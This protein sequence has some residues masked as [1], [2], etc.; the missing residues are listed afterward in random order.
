MLACI[1]REPLLCKGGYST[2]NDSSL[3]VFARNPA[4]LSDSDYTLYFLQEFM[5]VQ[6]PSQNNWAIKTRK[7]SYVIERRSDGR[8][9]IAFHW[10]PSE[11][12]KVQYAHVHAEMVG[13][14]RK[15]HIPT[16]RVP[17]EDVVSFAIH[18][19]GV[20]PLQSKWKR[21]ILEA[22]EVFMGQKTW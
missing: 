16:G 10:D 18:E 20:K 4:R 8:E 5:V 19:L 17:I 15:C 2:P 1:T 9:I 6:R 13:L 11:S 14:N 12:A 22:R 7:Y 21:T 3:F